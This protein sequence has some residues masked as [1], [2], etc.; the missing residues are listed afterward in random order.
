MQ[1]INHCLQRSGHTTWEINKGSNK[2]PA[3][4]H[5]ALLLVRNTRHYAGSLTACS[6]INAPAHGWKP[7]RLLYIYLPTADGG[8]TGQNMVG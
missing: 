8:W 3:I 7:R 6:V 5:K 1:I 4:H 2:L